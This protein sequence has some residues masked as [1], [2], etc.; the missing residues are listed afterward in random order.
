[1]K[2][3]LKISLNKLGIDLPDFDIQEYLKIILGILSIKKGFFEFTFTNNEII[4]NINKEF[5]NK[6]EPTDVISFNLSQDDY[7]IGDVY[8]SIEMAK[9]NAKNLNH[10]LE[11]EI[12]ILLIHA[13]L[14]LLGHK[15]YSESEFKEMSV[16]QN[17][18]FLIANKKL[19][20]LSI[21][22]KNIFTSFI[23]AFKGI[24]FTIYSQRNMKIHLF[25]GFLVIMAGLFLK[26]TRLEWEL[27]IL[28]I[29]FVLITEMI[30]TSMEISVDLTTKKRKFRAMLSK[31]IAAG[32][33][34]LSALNA[35][36][37]AS[38]IFLPKFI[39]LIKKG[40]FLN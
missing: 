6:N 9:F 26:L 5:L 23:Y 24:W 10:S 32:A 21:G 20:R 16:L 22:R 39:I 7:L 29:T 2:N 4:K 38:F 11:N 30:N 35:I 17:K 1:M 19:T 18:I 25:I 14:H 31:D 36:I 40:V 8:I 27:I 3:S 12:K 34:L 13:I 28:S 33:V 37:I 15:D